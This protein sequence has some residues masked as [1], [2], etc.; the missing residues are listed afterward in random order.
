MRAVVLLSCAACNSVLGLDHTTQVPSDAAVDAASF[1]CMPF[2]TYH[3]PISAVPCPDYTSDADGQVRAVATCNRAA[4][5]QLAEGPPGSTTLTDLVIDDPSSGTL[6]RA[7]VFPSGDQMVARAQTPANLSRPVGFRV[8]SRLASGVWSYQFD[9][10]FADLPIGLVT[11]DMVSTPTA[12]DSNRHI[13]LAHRDAQLNAQELREYAE[14]TEPTM[15]WTLKNI[16][17]PAGF[18][19]VDIGEPYLSPDGLAL[20]F[21]AAFG[22]GSPRLA[23]SVRSDIRDA[24]VTLTRFDTWNL[25]DEAAPFLTRD[26]SKLYLTTKGETELATP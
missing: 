4:G 23:L 11:T 15:P 21:V 7:R 3:A 14:D 25:N 12:S 1:P 5:P 18:S 8:Y 2:P 26:C 10:V 24:F 6:D 16:Y 9:L 20:V 17:T 19:E 22:T 13:I